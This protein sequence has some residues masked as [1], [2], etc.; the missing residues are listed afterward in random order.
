MSLFRAFVSIELCC[1]RWLIVQPTC[2]MN[3]L[4]IFDCHFLCQPFLLSDEN[5]YMFFMWCT[6][7]CQLLNAV[8]WYFGLLSLYPAHCSTP[9]KSRSINSHRAFLMNFNSIIT[10]IIWIFQIKSFTLRWISWQ[11]T[12]T[13]MLHIWLF[14]WQPCNIM[15]SRD[16]RSWISFL[17]Y[18]QHTTNEIAFVHILSQAQPTLVSLRNG[19]RTKLTVAHYPYAIEYSMNWN[20]KT[21]SLRTVAVSWWAQLWNNRQGGPVSIFF[22]N[23]FIAFVRLE[24]HLF[25]YFLFARLHTEI[26]PIRLHCNTPCQAKPHRISFNLFYFDFGS[27]SAALF[28]AILKR[29]FC[30]YVA[31]T[32]FPRRCYYSATKL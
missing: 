27:S 17:F 15:I 1:P 29:F 26:Y 25:F 19:M 21:T 20:N 24:R 16:F 14:R 2:S 10:E 31:V 6:D 4:A 13:Q 9:E 28:S 30:T 12:A 18:F 7:I 11:P 5:R 22:F 8:R 32:F 23:L 3:I